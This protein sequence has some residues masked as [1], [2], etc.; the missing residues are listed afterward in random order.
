MTEIASLF[1]RQ[2]MTST[3]ISDFPE[4]TV[5]VSGDFVREARTSA[6]PHF[7]SSPSSAPMVSVASTGISNIETLVNLFWVY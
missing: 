2:L 5:Q 3:R 7:G 6:L 1:A 4:D